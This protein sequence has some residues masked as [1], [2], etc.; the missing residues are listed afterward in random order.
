M[1]TRE[2]NIVAH[3]YQGRKVFILDNSNQDAS[4]FRW[5]IGGDAVRDVI[6]E[7]RDSNNP[8]EFADGAVVGSVT[9]TFE[10]PPGADPDKVFDPESGFE[11][12]GEII[13]VRL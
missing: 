2:V 11:P 1:D 13:D 6:Q 5:A 12:D 3:T 9:F 10:K 8:S 4:R 7:T